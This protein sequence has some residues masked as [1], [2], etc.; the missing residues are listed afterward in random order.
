M[1]ADETHVNLEREEE[2]ERHSA[3]TNWP[4]WHERRPSIRCTPS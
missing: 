2:E 3:E 4:E 1:H